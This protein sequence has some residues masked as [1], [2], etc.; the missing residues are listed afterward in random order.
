MDYGMTSNI[1]VF[2]YLPRVVVMLVCFKER[3]LTYLC[4]KVYIV[5]HVQTFMPNI[6][7]HNIHSLCTY[8]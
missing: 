7:F 2:S 1:D 5:H 6:L 8:E 3:K 4:D